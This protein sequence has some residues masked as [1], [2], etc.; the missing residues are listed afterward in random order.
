MEYYLALKK[1][2]R[3]HGCTDRPG[4]RHAGDEPAAEIQLLQVL[5]SAW[6]LETQ[7]HAA[8]APD[9]TTQASISPAN[10]HLQ[11]SHPQR[12]GRGSVTLAHAGP[13]QAPDTGLCRRQHQRHTGPGPA[14][15]AAST[16]TAP[17]HFRARIPRRPPCAFK[18]AVLESCPTAGLVGLV[19]RLTGSASRKHQAR[20][21][22]LGAL[23]CPT[24]HR[25]AAD[26]SWVAPGPQ[27][28]TPRPG[29][30]APTEHSADRQG[31][32]KPGAE[33]DSGAGTAWGGGR[34]PSATH[35][36]TR[37]EHPISASPAPGSGP[38]AWHVYMA[39]SHRGE[40]GG[41]KGLGQW[42]PHGETSAHRAG[43]RWGGGAAGGAGP[44]EAPSAGASA[45]RLEG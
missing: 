24:A 44:P 43:C 41:S 19:A 11:Q 15:A 12:A 38:W 20:S 9:S 8:R 4:G 2:T 3:L 10:Q 34:P 32:T 21:R 33:I 13:S 31:R 22:R 39:P 16:A 29:T 42:R 36:C 23:P 30:Q 25:P 6:G 1:K 17:K 7:T 27:L 45:N 28:S 40:A 37:W 26:G 35:T 5:R 18:L 14:C